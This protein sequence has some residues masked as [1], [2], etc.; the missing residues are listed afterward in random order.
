MHAPATAPACASDASREELLFRLPQLKQKTAQARFLAKHRDLV[1]A[2]VVSWLAELVRERAKID[3]GP[4]MTLAEIA[5]AIARKLGDQDVIA[6]SLRAKGNALY[7]TGQNRSAIRY[8]RRACNIFTALGSTNQLARTLNA[9]IQPLILTGQYERAF[10]AAEEARNIFIADHNEWRLARVELNLGNILHRQDR[11][12]EALGYYQRSVR[13]FRANP[14]QDPEAFAV[15][16]HNAA[17]CLVGLNDFPHALAAYEEARQF[18][19]EHGM[20]VLVGQSD[21][22][23]A[24]LYYFQGNHTRAIEILRATRETC[25]TTKDEYHAALCQLDLSEI[26]LEV[27]Q[28]KEAAD[29]AGQAASDF[30]RLEMGYEAGKSLANVA[31]AMWQQGRA[32]DALDLFANARKVFLKEKNRIWSSRIDTYRAIIL[33]EQGQHVEAQRLCRAALKVFHASRVSYSLI[34]CHL[35][36]AH[37]YLRAMKGL[38]ARRHCEAALK[39]LRTIDLPVLRSHAQ[40][41]MG[42]VQAAMSRPAEAHACY[43]EARRILEQLRGGLSREEL[44]ISFM[45]NR[46]VIYEE[47]VDLCL[48]GKTKPHLEEAFRHIEQSKSRSLRD[49][50]SNAGSEFHLASGLDPKLTRRVHDLRAEINWYSRKYEAEQLGETKT[51]PERLARIQAQIRKREDELLQVAREMPVPVAESAGLISLDPV[52]L[53]EI[54]SALSPESTLLEYFQ[55]RDHLVAVVLNHDTLEIVPIAAL[56]QVN[57]LIARLHFQ[58]SKFKLSAEYIAAFGKSLMETTLR[59]SK[60]LYEALLRPIRNRLTGNRL[61]IVPHGSLHSLPFQALFDGSEYLIDSYSISYAPSA[62]VFRLCHTRIANRNGGALVLGIPDASAPVVLDEVQTVAATIPRSQLFL[63]EAAT[64]NLLRAKGELSSLIHIATHGYFRQDNP[65]FSGIRL[66]D[67]I[68]SL[69]DLYQLRLPAELITLSGCATGLSVV[70]DGDELL[71]LVR[72]LIHAGAQS[73]LLTLWDVHDRSTAE[74]M[75]LFYGHWSRLGDKSTA[76]RLAMLELRNRYPHP[77]HWAPFV[78]VGG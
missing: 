71:G 44:R 22:N 59:H 20:H 58:L 13:Y 14:K 75:A 27:N 36:L 7:L 57:D 40:H 30:Q 66:G 17:M 67:G 32:Q 62:T 15:G 77:Y 64:V 28:S 24:S 45:K 74:F 55:I 10:A 16:L 26:Y 56:S 49:L 46:L 4:T 48:A 1:S 37:L 25:R 69:Y 35:L 9:S 78:L 61:L 73:A 60:D 2:D 19:V 52:T 53:E 68:L 41:L 31:L 65:M 29:M 50:M 54:R 8:H 3:T 23:I 34:Q 72:G 18:A 43:E 6:Q 38:L 21:Y 76:L 5:V 47:L 63:G 42:R 51:P 11:F 12:A 70:T 33:I 39:R